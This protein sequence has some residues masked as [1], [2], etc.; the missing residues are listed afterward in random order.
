MDILEDTKLVCV[1][2]TLKTIKAVPT[3]LSQTQLQ[4]GI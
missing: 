1:L 2:E 4:V 3:R